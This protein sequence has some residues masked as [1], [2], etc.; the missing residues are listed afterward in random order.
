VILP[1]T[2]DQFFSNFAEYNRS[3]W[4]VAVAFW[5]VTAGMLASTWRQPERRSRTLAFLLALLWTWNAVAYHVWLFTRI[6]PA[7]W[8]FAALFLAEAALLVDAGIRKQIEFFSSSKSWRNVV[9]MTLAVYSLAYPFVTIASGHVYPA[10]P[11]FGVPCPTAI[12]TIGLLLTVRGRLPARLAAV[13]TLWGFVGGSAA[14]LLAVPA[15]YVLL[16]AGV[17]Q[18][19]VV[20][21]PGS[22]RG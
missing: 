10:T 18:A 13:P 1:F 17:L 21:A 15:D 11:T 9:G 22:R 12:L 5:C 6:N 14:V 19:G 20:I 4:F 7:A 3:F 8:L 16:A 2:S